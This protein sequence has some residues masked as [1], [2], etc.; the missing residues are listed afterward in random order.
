MKGQSQLTANEILLLSKYI[1]T[2]SISSSTVATTSTPVTSTPNV[3]EKHIY[4]VCKGCHGANGEKK[5]LGK[6]TVITG[7]DVA[8]TITQLNGYKAGT[9]N[10][11]GMGGLM[12]GQVASMDEA[13][14][15]AVA[16]YIAGMK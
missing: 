3:S 12:K 5:A 7:Q 4:A 15:K 14:I 10:Q 6:S 2:L 9:L 13:T 16:E 1:E 8:K 11:Y